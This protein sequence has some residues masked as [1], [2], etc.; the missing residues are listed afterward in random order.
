M[1]LKVKRSQRA[2]TFNNVIFMIDARMDI[3]KQDAD[4]IAKYKLG[5][6]TIYDSKQRQRHM[7]A[8]QDHLANSRQSAAWSA[9]AADHLLALGKT[10]YKLGS[11]GARLGM[12]ALSLRITVDSLCRGVHVECKSLD[13]VLEAEEAIMK[14]GENLRGYLETASTFDGR[15]QVFEF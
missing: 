15:E 8:S 6:L 11:A 10:I 1:Q 12:A 5:G 13:E 9:G 7:D 2:T 14:A 4:L 3:S